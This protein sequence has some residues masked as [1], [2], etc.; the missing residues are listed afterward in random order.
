MESMD[1]HCQW[2]LFAKNR[3]IVTIQSIVRDFYLNPCGKICASVV[4][5]N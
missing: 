3:M 1:A 4:S 5:R 2:P